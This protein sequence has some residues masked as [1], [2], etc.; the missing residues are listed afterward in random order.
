MPP[1][2]DARHAQP[3]GARRA[4]DGVLRRLRTAG[5]RTAVAQL[6]ALLG[7]SELARTIALHTGSNRVDCARVG[8]T[9]ADAWGTSHAPAAKLA[10]LAVNEVLGALTD[11][12]AC[13]LEQVDAFR[14]A[15]ATLAHAGVSPHELAPVAGAMAHK[16]VAAGMPAPALLEAAAMRQCVAPRALDFP[17]G[18]PAL[19]EALVCF[20]DGAPH[21]DTQSAALA[22][23]LALAARADAPAIAR[24]LVAPGGP[25][26]A[27]RQ[28]RAAD[29][30][31]ADRAAYAAERAVARYTAGDT[32]MGAFDCRMAVLG[33]L[34]HTAVDTAA[35]WDRAA[36][37][38]ASH[39]HAAVPRA[40]IHAA[41]HALAA[42]VP[43]TEHARSVWLHL[44]RGDP[45]AECDVLRIDGGSALA[46]ALGALDIDAHADRASA[47]LAGPV[48]AP[49]LGALARALAERLDGAP[50]AAHVDLA[51]AALDAYTRLPPPHP[52][53]LALCRALCAHA[54]ARDP[55][56][57]AVAALLARAEAAA[58]DAPALVHHVSSV[59]YHYGSRA[60]AAHQFGMAVRLLTRCVAAAERAGDSAEQLAP[61]RAALGAACR[62]ADRHADAFAAYAAA[63][64]CVDP[65]RVSERA[66][67]MD[68]AAGV[69]ADDLALWGK[70]VRGLAD[71]SVLGGG[72]D[73]CAAAATL[74]ADVRGAVLEYA[75][76]HVATYAQQ[77][78]AAAALDAL[79]A[80][81][82]DAYGAAYPVRAARVRTVRALAH[83]LAGDAPPAVTVPPATGADVHLGAA[84]EAYVAAALL[85]DVLRDARAPA[86]APAARA[87]D[88]LMRLGDRALCT[89]RTVNRPRTARAR[90]PAPT[91]KRA[92]DASS[93]DA[94]ACPTLGDFGLAAAYALYAAGDDDGA[95]ALFH[96]LA[97]APAADV[98]DARAAARTAAAHLHMNAG[99]VHEPPDANE[100]DALLA[101]ARAAHARG[102][103]AH[104]HYAAAAALPRPPRGP[105]RLEEQALA[106]VVYAELAPAHAPRAA[107]HALRARLQ[108]AAYTKRASRE[109]PLAAATLHWRI[110]RG[111][112]E[113]YMHVSRAYAA[114]GCARDALAFAREAVTYAAAAR[115]PRLGAAAHVWLADLEL[116]CGN[117]GACHAALEAAHALGGAPAVAA[118][119][120]AV[121]ADA[122]LA[123]GAPRDAATL[124]RT[125][126]T[127][128][129]A[130][131]DAH[132]G[133][134]PVR[135]RKSGAHDAVF[136]A[137]SCVLARALA[138]LG[139][140]RG[141]LA[142]AS[143]ATPAARITRASLVLAQASACLHGD[144]VWG[145]LPE[146]ATSIPAPGAPAAGAAAHRA[147][148]HIDAARELVLGA[149]SALGPAGDART[150]RTGLD[151]LRTA[152][153]LDALLRR[154][155]GAHVAALM[156]A[157]AS[158]AA[159]RVAAECGTPAP[160]DEWLGTATPQSPDAADDRA[161]LRASLSW[162]AAPAGAPI[163]ERVR[164]SLP[165][166]WA[167]VV[168][169]LS[170]DR[171]A[172]HVARI[173]AD[174][175]VFILP[176]ERQSAREGEAEELTADAVLG[177]LRAI[178]ADSNAHVKEAQHVSALEA[179]K[180]W[181]AARRALDARLGALLARVQDVWL[182]A[183]SA[184]L[185]PPR[186]LP[187]AALSALRRRV[188]DT[189][190]K[191][192]A[193][194][195]ARI[196]AV[197]A[198]ALEC[199]ARL[200]ADTPHDIIEDWLHYA[201][202]TLTLSGAPIAQDEADLDEMCVD[203]QS[204]L[205]DAH[206]AA[207][208]ADAPAGH[209][210]LVLDRELCEFPWESLPALRTHSVSRVPSLEFLLTRAPLA[211]RTLDPARTAYLL[212]PSGDL[213]RSEE[214]FGPWLTAHPAWRGTTGRAP[215]IDEFAQALAM[216]DTFLYFGHSGGEQ[217][218]RATRLRALDS[219]AATMLWGCSSGVL[220]AHGEFDRSGTPLDYMAA[221]CPALVAGLWDTTDRELDS[222]CEA[223]L[224]GVGLM[225]GGGPEHLPLPAAVAAARSKCRLP[226]LTGAA[227]VVY[228]I[229]V[230]W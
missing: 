8:P 178:T 50:S 169:T 215:V 49:A 84:R 61:R 162:D 190:A 203:L 136:A 150:V 173:A 60:Y 110:A 26:D 172:L 48:D 129:R 144:A 125:A 229:P 70:V 210:V 216:H 142:A 221:A 188:H 226:H 218:V 102:A 222:V 34:A 76:A 14:I 177:E 198:A 9:W 202:D 94:P 92:A 41:L 147:H 208:A 67:R 200:P 59:L 121:G 20:A 91:P 75:A 132:P 54:A 139:D 165:P 227:I 161:P 118:R 56:G 158:L 55:S 159:R 124:A 32:S 120:A 207:R 7:A 205:E 217:Y 90:A 101:A 28:V 168:L 117:G 126:I 119:A 135:A 174:T 78:G 151:V 44:V 191:A 219:C 230:R 184:L 11:A 186:P 1:R 80:A 17:L 128:W 5:D 111:V 199:L 130:L 123:A 148:T 33:M 187:P 176:I 77:R 62:G 194:T 152:H 134:R 27:Q 31:A 225:D 153:V 201:M 212:N 213:V 195:H 133:E 166:T 97:H 21:L 58:G 40:H 193:R 154:A 52:D 57:D 114:L 214:R 24:M 141:A 105:R 3:P 51:Y 167:A 87:A 163:V 18:T 196:P 100:V 137:A 157:Q 146:I 29:P 181:W 81:A 224:R 74:P 45:G 69:F 35:L 104:A 12:R 53:A 42:H 170:A 175:D 37:T 149:L 204:A 206:R 98:R 36:R 155:D 180:A 143:L 197:R 65:A 127:Q 46:D 25:A 10:K 63:L 89:S 160:T 39:A 122:L 71:A 16:L 171:R 85:V 93:P 4:P 189:L 23:G 73:V 19:L 179:R 43:P 72:G 183:F 192:C 116:A 79:L 182:G 115:A 95:L 209:T 13:T 47:A 145:A 228:G 223:V 112:F 86:G 156:N 211:P 64:A 103:P 82:E 113:S 99:V 108:A 96:A 15:M 83:V 30:A 22:A 131:A 106:A 220:C 140:A 38:A 6:V 88:A 68:P 2:R 109:P 107:V 164:A 66:A 185:A 138:A